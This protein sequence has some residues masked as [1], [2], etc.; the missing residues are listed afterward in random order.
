[1][2]VFFGFKQYILNSDM[3]KWKWNC[4]TVL[5]QTGGGIYWSGNDGKVFIIIIDY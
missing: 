5:T 1:M 3:N 4:M 2:C